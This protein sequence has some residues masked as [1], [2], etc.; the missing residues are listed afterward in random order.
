MEEMRIDFTGDVAM[1][2]ALMFA[3]DWILAPNE[4]VWALTGGGT[5]GIQR[6]PPPPNA[7]GSFFQM[8]H[9]KAREYDGIED[10][11]NLDAEPRAR[12]Y[13]IDMKF[14]RFRVALLKSQSGWHRVLRVF[15]SEMPTLDKVGYPDS[16]S[17]ILMTDGLQRGMVIFSG[18]PRAWKTTGAS[19]YLISLLHKR[20]GHAITLEDPPEA[21]L[22]GEHGKGVCMQIEVTRATMAD[23][24]VH[25]L[26][27]GVPTAVMLGEIRDGKTMAEALRASINGHFLV[28]TMHA[29]GVPETLERIRALTMESGLSATATQALMSTGISMI[30]NQHL[31][32]ISGATDPTR[33]FKLKAQAMVLANPWGTTA[34]RSLIASGEFRKIGTELERQ[35]STHGLPK[36]EAEGAIPKRI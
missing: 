11:T 26:R 10:E 35:A 7:L 3:A 19:S 13:A 14:K 4:E 30:V 29:S 25:S 1:E 15:P 34:M 12:E 2:D 18:P 32:E 16:I 20:G 28:A 24:L 33:Q 6:V 8:V 27:Y 5:S 9:N 23:Q 22:E 36:P 31:Y 17:D 21:E